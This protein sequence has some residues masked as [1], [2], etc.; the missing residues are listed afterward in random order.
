MPLLHPQYVNEPN[1]ITVYIVSH[2]YFFSD[3]MRL[4]FEMCL[5]LGD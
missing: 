4:T 1:E 2:L 3:K 5:A